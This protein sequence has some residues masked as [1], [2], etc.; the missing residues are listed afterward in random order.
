LAAYELGIFALAWILDRLGRRGDDLGTLLLLVA[1]FAVVTPMAVDAACVRHP[2][3]CLGLGCVG[4]GLVL[5][6]AGLVWRRLASW[7]PPTTL[8]ALGTVI[9]L[10][11]LLGAFIGYAPPEYRLGRWFIGAA[12]HQAA[13]VA[14]L[15]ALLLRRPGAVVPGPFAVGS[16][17]FRGGLLAIVMG[18]GQLHLVALRYG[19][20]HLDWPLLFPPLVLAAWGYLAWRHATGRLGEWGT[21]PAT[22]ATLGLGILITHGGVHHAT[23]ETTW[24]AVLEHPGVWLLAAGGATALLLWRRSSLPLLVQAGALV[25]A[26]FICIA[27]VPGLSP[28]PT[29]RWVL[30]P[31][32]VLVQA[33]LVA[34]AAWK[35]S[36][37]AALATVVLGV[38]GWY[39]ACGSSVFPAWWCLPFGA[40]AA[41]AIWG[42]RFTKAELVGIALATA[43]VGLDLGRATWLQWSPLPQLSWVALGLFCLVAALRCRL[44]LLV[45]PALAPALHHLA[46]LA[47][48]P[49]AWLLVGA[50]FAL[51][52]V[53]ALC[54]LGLPRGWFAWCF[55]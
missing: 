20:H 10:Q 34:L 48:L 12:V 8:A 14:M 41:V 36:R 16:A 33:G 54:S 22:A 24:L 4:L 17:T 15:A 3:I 46:H 49:A 35:R 25:L 37:H 55:A 32:W 2:G 6:K 23:M 51:L 19:F 5:L 30:A 50:A 1:I 53:G 44:P 39:L 21:L 13:A 29:W 27:H 47:E 28:S 42:R 26:G 45:L 31:S 43:V 40:L 7:L 38:L 11:V 9:G 52:G 18:L